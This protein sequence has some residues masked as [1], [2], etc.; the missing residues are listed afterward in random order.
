MSNFALVP[1]AYDFHINR[2]RRGHWIVSERHD[3]SGGVFLTRKDAIRFALFEAG[4]DAS[5]VHTDRTVGV[6]RPHLGRT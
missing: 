5:H 4:G 1:S 3:L 6:S 2:D